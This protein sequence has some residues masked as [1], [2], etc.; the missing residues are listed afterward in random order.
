MHHLDQKAMRAIIGRLPTVQRQVIELA[1][2]RGLTQREIARETSS[3]LGTVKSRVRL[4]LQSIRRMLFE[5]A[6]DGPM[7]QRRLA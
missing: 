6:A 5:S 7:E 1:S 2:L 4:G 3:P